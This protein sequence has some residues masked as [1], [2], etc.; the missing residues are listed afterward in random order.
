MSAYQEQYD[1]AVARTALN[2]RIKELL[3]NGLG[4]EIRPEL[5]GDDQPLFGR[6]LELDSLDTLEIV[7]MIDEEFGVAISDD[8]RA[9]FGSIN[10]IADLVVAERGAIPPVDA[11]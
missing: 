8:D 1:S 7:V 11:A 2:H 10:K 6:G 3:V 5:V 9:V 4:L